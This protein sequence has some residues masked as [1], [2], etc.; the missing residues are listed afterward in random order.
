MLRPRAPEI[1]DDAGDQRRFGTD[2]GQIDVVGLSQMIV[3]TGG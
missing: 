2:D 3:G 1:V